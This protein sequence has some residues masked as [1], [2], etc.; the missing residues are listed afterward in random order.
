M[1]N[2]SAEISAS[3]LMVEALT[4]TVQI[5]TTVMIILWFT[6]RWKKMEGSRRLQDGGPAH[7]SRGRRIPTQLRYALAF[8]SV[9]VAVT[10]DT[11]VRPGLGP[12]PVGLLFLC[13]VVGCAWYGGVGPGLVALLLSVLALEYF[14]LPPLHSLKVSPAYLPDLIGFF[15]FAILSVWFS[16]ARRQTENELKRTAEEWERK[17]RTATELMEKAQ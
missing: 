10:V 5:A 15:L 9:G 17:W 2:H 12:L 6:D 14:F 13:A 3:L 7:L 4:L 16:A 11:L 1:N 8:A